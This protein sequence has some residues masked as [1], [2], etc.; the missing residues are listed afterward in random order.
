MKEGAG[1]NDDQQA[2]TSSQAKE[3]IAEANVANNIIIGE[4]CDILAKY[5][6]PIET[7]QVDHDLQLPEDANSSIFSSDED[8]DALVG[9]DVPQAAAQGAVEREED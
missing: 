8:E 1:L 5:R 9:E 7:N 4:D 3:E 2:E 6:I